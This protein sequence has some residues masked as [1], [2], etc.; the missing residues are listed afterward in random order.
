MRMHA[1]A[2]SLWG[3]LH[4]Q[5]LCN[6][7]FSKQVSCFSPRAQPIFSW[8]CPCHQPDYLPEERSCLI[9]TLQMTPGSHKRHQSHPSHLPENG[10]GLVSQRKFEILFQFYNINSDYVII[11]MKENR[12][13][14]VNTKHSSLYLSLNP[15]IAIHHSQ[16]QIY[17]FIW[18][19]FRFMQCCY[20]WSES[21]KQ[22]GVLSLCYLIFI[23]LFISISIAP[24]CLVT[25]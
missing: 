12:Y 13:W 23:S 7:N 24:A 15:L 11:R 18:M 17:H 19:L 4:C 25:Q 2:L 5:V 9:K 10:V 20:F 22:K 14:A 16:I 1:S 21:G 6:G 8:L 3:Q